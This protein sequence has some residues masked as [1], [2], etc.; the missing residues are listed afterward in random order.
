[1]PTLRNPP[2]LRPISRRAHRPSSWAPFLAGL[3]GLAGLV[4]VLTLQL[5]E[6]E[7]GLRRE[8][9]LRNV[10][11]LARLAATRLTQVLDAAAGRPPGSARY[12]EAHLEKAADGT[13]RVRLPVVGAGSGAPAAPVP[14]QADTITLPLT[15]FDTLLAQAATGRDGAATIRT[16]D[17]RLVQ[18]HPA[19]PPGSPLIGGQTTSPELRA[20]MDRRP[21]Q[22]SYTAVTALD[23]I[24]R[25]N[26]FQ[27]VAGTPFLVIVGVPERVAPEGWSRHDLPI[28]TLAVVALLIATGGTF[29]LYRLSL[30]RVSQAQRRWQSIVEDSEDAIITKALDGTVLDWNSAAERILGW[31]AADMVGRP[32]LSIV[33]PERHGEEAAIMEKLGRGERIEG[34]ETLRATKD[35]RQV[36]LSMTISPIRDA[37]DRVVGACSISRDISRQKALEAEIRLQA[38]MDPLTRLPN[39]RLF[40]DRLAQAQVHGRRSGEWHALLYLDLDGF[41]A[42]NDTHGHDAGDRCLEAVARRLTAAVRETDTVARLGGDEFIVLCEGLGADEAGARLRVI[43]VIRKVEDSLSEPLDLGGTRVSMCASIGHVLFQGTAE[44]GGELVRRADQAM[45]RIKQAR[46]RAAR[47]AATAPP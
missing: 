15:A 5:I 36:P 17:L 34:L 30:Q 9:A 1:M 18:R 39:R 41:K 7:R 22:G 8:A 6:H 43:A 32:M 21:E 2:P 27:R 23:G 11:T 45:Y 28:L 16:L 26:A 33:P 20:L 38:L 24:A 19:P 40:G 31:S 4:T 25:V 12:P 37:A 3:L 35:G 47:E 46:R 14:S 29:W 13:W 44:D 10:E 42:L